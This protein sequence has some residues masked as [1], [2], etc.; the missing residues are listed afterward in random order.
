MQ[1]ILWESS[2]QSGLPSRTPC[3]SNSARRSSSL[4]LSSR[5]SSLLASHHPAAIADQRPHEPVEVPMPIQEAPVEPA[6]IVVL[7]I[8]IVVAV[9]G[10]AHLVAHLQ[11]RGTD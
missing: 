8:G 4:R 9:L 5:L 2:A 1:A 3:Q 6:H 11:H 10:A 7:A